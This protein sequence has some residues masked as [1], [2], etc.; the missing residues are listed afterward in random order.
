MP[1]RIRGRQP[2]R[3]SG[4]RHT[5]RE[6]TEQSYHSGRASLENMH[7]KGSKQTR[8]ELTI[9]KLIPDTRNCAV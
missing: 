9:I 5:S 4:A 6:K 8:R 1:G 7:A 2:G 3:A